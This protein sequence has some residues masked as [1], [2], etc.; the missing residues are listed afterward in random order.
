VLGEVLT[1]AWAELEKG[2]GKALA[3]A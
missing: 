1:E 2:R 3:Q